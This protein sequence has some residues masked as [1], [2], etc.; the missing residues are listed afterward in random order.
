MECYR[1]EHVSYSVGS[2]NFRI[3]CATVNRG[4]VWKVV[5]EL[6]SNANV[7]SPPMG[8]Q[9]EMKSAGHVGLGSRMKQG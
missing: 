7:I 1:E 9:V 4:I 2:T 8:R 5:G 6:V 3:K